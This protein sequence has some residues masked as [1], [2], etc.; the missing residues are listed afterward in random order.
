MELV[1]VFAG[2]C[3]VTDDRL[4]MGFGQSAGLSHVVVFGDVFENGDGCK[5]SLDTGQ[6]RFIATQP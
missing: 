1:G 6:V 4:Q 2:E 5:T 3:R